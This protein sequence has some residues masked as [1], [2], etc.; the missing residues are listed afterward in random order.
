M[1]PDR[2]RIIAALW[3][4]AAVVPVALAL[5]WMWRRFTPADALLLW[6]FVPVALIAAWHVWRLR[7]RRPRALLPT[8]PTLLRG[9]RG[10]LTA[11]RH[12][13]FS[14]ALAGTGLLLVAM[15]RPQ[16]RDSWQDVER[17][18]IDI[19]LALDVS[20]SMLAKDLKPDRMEAAKRTAIEFIEAR[21]NDRIGLVV[22][23]G[24]AF[25]QCPLTTDHAVLKDLFQGVRSGLMEGGT[26]IGMGLATALNRLRESEAKSK[27]VIL[28]TDGVNNAGVMQPMDAAQIAEALGVRVYAI[29]VGTRGKALSPVARYP[30]GQYRFD[31]IDV[32]IDDALLERIATMTGGRYFRATDEKKLR[33]IYREIDELER[34]RVR[35]TEFSQR[36]EEYFPIAAAGAGLLLLGFLFDRTLLRTMA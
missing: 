12:L 26:A 11:L 18:G 30:N 13:P 5:V 4:L 15:T 21:P 23:E 27:V 22:Y 10:P 16:S 1:R 36:H 24:E 28:L 32:E 7:M 29:G 19:V 31:Y 34:T 14:L 2:E 35:V 25:T 33:E 3:A 20:A 6:A 9:P 17:E 8:M